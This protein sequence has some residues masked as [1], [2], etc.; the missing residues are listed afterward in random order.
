MDMKEK[1]VL[2]LLQERN[3]ESVV[4]CCEKF[5]L[6]V[7]YGILSNLL[8]IFVYERFLYVN[9]Y[10][11]QSK[12]IHSVPKLVISTTVLLFFSC[13]VVKRVPPSKKISFPCFLNHVTIQW[14]QQ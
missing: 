4:C 6:C 13:S 12:Y 7:L 3:C 2:S 14:K 9:R 11:E 10:K 5:Q 1:M 8:R